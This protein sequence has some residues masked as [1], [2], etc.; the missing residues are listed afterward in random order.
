M[1]DIKLELTKTP[2]EKPDPHHLP[3]GDIPTDHMFVMNYTEGKGWHDPRIVPYGPISL[4]PSAMVLHYAQ[5]VFE[6]MKAYR[7]PDDR[8]LL[9]RPME[10]VKRL[11]N[12]C[13]RLCIPQLNEEDVLQA[14]TTLV[15]VEQD[16]IPRLKDTSLYIRPFVFATEPHLGVRPARTYLFMII[17][18]PVGAYYPE[19]LDPVK[20]YMETKYVRAVP[21]GVGHVKTG[22]NY[23][24]SLKSQVEAEESGY[25]QVL[26]LD[27][28]ERRYIEEVGAVN[29]MFKVD[30]KIITP[31]LHGS[32]LPGITRKSAIQALKYMGYE[33]EERRIAIDELYEL[34][35]ADKLEE[36][37][38]TGT[39]AVISPVGEIKWNDHIMPINNEK[40]GEVSQKLYD[41]L[42]DIQNGRIEDPFG[43]SYEVK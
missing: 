14:I 11:N 25:H 26:W 29:M 9:F 38:G 24:S 40:I 7:A 21:G 43:W 36:A 35:K 39:A 30:G 12:S 23:A 33:V 4:D 1:L 3:F 2:K 32:V 18:C 15:K 8:I 20:I 13:D 6:G 22:G 17:L 16:W 41:F 5:E 37:F 10:N 19:G 27:G 31:E 34:W 42:T 28:V